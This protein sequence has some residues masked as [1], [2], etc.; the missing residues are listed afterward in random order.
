MASALTLLL[1][2]FLNQHALRSSQSEYT[3]LVL[4]GLPSTVLRE[5]FN[6]LTQGDG[7]SW[8]PA[9]RNQIPILLVTGVPKAS[10]SG[11]S[12]ECNWDYALSIRNS[13]PSFV[14][15]VD[16][17]VWDD[18]TYSII[19]AT[20]TIGL[21]LPPIR[22][23]VP[24]LRNWSALYA[25][26]VEMAAVR[27][28]IDTSVVESAIR[29]TLKDLPSLDPTQQHR[30]PWEVLDKIAGLAILDRSVTH[31]DLARVCGLPSL[32]GDGDDFRRRRRVLE[33]L[34]EFLE[35]VGIEE[36]IQEL[37]VTSRGSE[38]TQ[39]LNAIGEELR[40]SAGAASAIVRAP[41]FYFANQSTESSWWSKLTVEVLEEMLAEIGR[42]ERFWPDFCVMQQCIEPFSLTWR[43]ISGSGG[44][45]HR[46]KASRRSFP[47]VKVAAQNWAPESDN[48][49]L[50]RGTPK[51]FQLR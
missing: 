23:N 15:L 20:D 27:I 35:D 3:R 47:V 37:R 38:L 44:S 8:Q 51:P 2:D 5:L 22:R 24:P 49:N 48:I 29:E 12:R 45:T 42:T 18:R 13:Y 4:G 39:E 19:N 34:A 30:L 10:G 43:T 32:R 50:N 7:S 6:V 25:N 40:E 17:L 36:G 11:P 28:G 41:S 31:N 1:V 9:Q 33:R 14:L 21:P 46:S 26:V 16:P